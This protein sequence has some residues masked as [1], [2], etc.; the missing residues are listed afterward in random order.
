MR[1]LFPAV[2]MFLC[3]P[4]YEAVASSNATRAWNFRVLLEGNDIGYH[5]F[6]LEERDDARVLSSK[7]EF[8][9][10]FLFFNAFRYRHDDVETW[11]DGCLRQ[12]EAKTVTNDKTRVVS[13]ATTDDGFVVSRDGDTEELPQCVMTFAYW[14]PEFLK[15]PQLLNPQTGEYLDV[16]IEKLP[17]QSVN[18][19]GESVLAERYS[20]KARGA[21][22]AVEVWYAQDDRWIGLESVVKGG[23]K[24]RYELTGM[25]PPPQRDYAWRVPR[26]DI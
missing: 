15:E 25:S 2:L 6:E 5:R 9:V 7:A 19:A 13:G 18:V 12:L 8:D 26:S 20:I 10:R 21:D 4:A 24:I 14:N 23:R 17:R 22:I 11:R 16:E 1:I 3:L